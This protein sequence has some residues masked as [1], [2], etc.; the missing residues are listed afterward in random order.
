MLWFAIFVIFLTYLILYWTQ[1]RG[2]LN[3][4]N[5]RASSSNIC[6]IY[7]VFTQLEGLLY[8]SFLANLIV[9]LRDAQTKKISKSFLPSFS[10]TTHY[11]KIVTQGREHFISFSCLLLWL[12]ILYIC[13]E[14]VMKAR[15]IVPIYNNNTWELCYNDVINPL[16][17]T[18]ESVSVLQCQKV[19]L[20]WEENGC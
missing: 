13:K 9:S 5:T 18:T 15:S 1:Y 16:L 3:L 2:F 10:L 17:L 19:S 12:Y 20:F 6:L 14:K 4:L 11:K 8:L 7:T